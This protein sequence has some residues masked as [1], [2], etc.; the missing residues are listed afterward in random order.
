MKLSGRNPVLERLRARPHSIQKIFLQENLSDG[1]PIY[2]I[3]KKFH[4]PIFV[5]AASKLVK[6]SHSMNSQG[7]LAE[8]EDFFY[9]DY[10]EVLMGA[11]QEKQTLLFL[12]RLNDPQNLGVII[13]S[14]ACLGGFAIILPTHDSVEVTEAVLRVASGADS[15][16]PIARVGNLS[17]AISAAKKEGFWIA[18]TVVEAGRNIMN[19]ALPFPL[20][21]VIGSEH[22]GIRDGLLK[23]ADILLTLPMPTAKLSFNVAQAAT[24]FCYEITRQKNKK[25]SQ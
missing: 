22:K 25:K 6:L 2:E 15:H 24:I 10:S 11:L 8:V 16:I 4:I 9:A 23:Q 7:V 14:A 1:G 18:G 12:D 19:E 13:R 20:G 3:A 5:V 17:Q 21:L